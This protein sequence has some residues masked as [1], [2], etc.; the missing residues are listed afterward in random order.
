MKKELKARLEGIIF[1]STDLTL[2]EKDYL[3]K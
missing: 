2:A 3:T 1:N